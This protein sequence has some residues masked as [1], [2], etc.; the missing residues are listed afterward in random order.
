MKRSRYLELISYAEDPYQGFLKY[1]GCLEEKPVSDRRY[2]DLCAALFDLGYV[3]YTGKG[4][5]EEEFL[6]LAHERISE[7]LEKTG[8]I[9]ELVYCDEDRR[10]VVNRDRKEPFFKPDFSPDTLRSF[11]Y[12]GGAL[13]IKRSN[14]KSFQ[15][16]LGESDY[17]RLAGSI[18][19]SFINNRTTFNSIHI[20][21]A[22]FH[23]E[24]ET[25][26]RYPEGVHP[27]LPTSPEGREKKKVRAVILSKNNKQLLLDCLDSFIKN[28]DMEM[29]YVVVDNGSEEIIRAEIKSELDKR[30]ICY[31]YSPMEF[32][33]SAL[34]NL[35]AGAE[36]EDYTHLLLLNDDIILPGGGK[37]F[38]SEL[39]AQSDLPHVG[40]VGV[41]LKYPDREGFENRIQ[42]VG[43]TLLK[44][45]PSHKLC[46][47]D[48][49]VVYERGRNRGIWNVMAV[50]GACMLIRRDRFEEVGGF[51]ERLHVSYT[52]VDLCMDLQKKGYY[53]IVLNDIFLIH[54]ES[55]TRGS[56]GADE[57]KAGR[58]IRER[59][60]FYEKHPELL[61]TG[62]RY[63]NPNLTKLRLDYTA[64]YP[65]PWEEEVMAEEIGIDN[66]HIKE[67]VKKLDGSIDRSDRLVPVFEGEEECVRLEGWCL[68]H[69]RDMLGYEPAVAAKTSEGYRVFEARRKIR[70]DLGEVFPDD[71]NVLLSGFVCRIRTGQL[72]AGENVSYHPAL[73]KNG[74][75]GTN[76][77]VLDKS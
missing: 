11:F 48:D 5:L 54:Y 69:G 28:S 62:D 47:Y 21:R 31:L 9:P 43:I 74:L 25:D 65:L 70:K 75:L 32:I 12:I 14:E 30:N 15:N 40:A 18:L 27:T 52:D 13:L 64:D 37:G 57:K 8:K 56:D 67:G 24:D 6:S 53:N 35:G 34:C 20:C 59:K 41:K 38:P 58:L 77:Y 46:T 42:H 39:V 61:E 33:Y 29:E 19:R 1:K 45:G 10:T 4:F 63:Y 23:S 68:I 55:L 17:L 16:Q 73:L 2:S 66:L 50:T 49:S 71:K 72:P 7:S 51:D 60:I 26:Y 22:L 36:G 76:L 3:L 44:N